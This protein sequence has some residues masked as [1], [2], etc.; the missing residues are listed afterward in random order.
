[1]KNRNSIFTTI[2]LGL[3]CFALLPGAQAVSPAPDGGYAGFNTAEGQN[4]LFSLTTGVGNTAVGWFSLWSNTD[5]SLN[6]GVGAG[7]LLFNVG[8]QTAGEGVYNTAIGTAAL[9]SN[10]TGN[11]N[12]ANGAFALFSNSTGHDNSACGSQAL[13]TNTTGFRNT[14]NGVQAL[15]SNATGVANTAN[16]YGTLYSNTEGGS[17]TANGDQALFNNAIGSANTADGVHALL[18]NTTGSGNT[19]VG[20]DAMASNTEGG[21]NTAVG[22]DALHSNST[23]IFNTAVGN[24]ALVNNTGSFNIA[25]RGGSN[26]TTGNFNIDIGSD[27]VAGESGTI[28]IGDGCCQSRAFMAGISGTGVSGSTVVVDANGQLGVTPSSARFKEQIKPMDQTSE[29]ILSLKPVSFHYTKE[30]DP[31]A[32]SQFGLVAEEV[33]EVNPDLVVRDKEGNPYSVRYDAVN[34]MLLNEFLKE[35]RKV[36]EQQTSIA[37]LKSTVAQQQK[38]MEVL[39]GKLKEQAAQIQ[40]V[41]AQ[42]EISKSRSQVVLKQ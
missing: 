31:A 9:L 40:K 36:E 35:H 32:R 3:A 38:G 7:T 15:F 5:G 14:A 8:N 33:A 16:G 30:I 10:T 4:A 28:R 20:V 18:H 41:S 22:R 21:D 11:N 2:L 29:A 23:G 6:T 17:N 1:M 42:L 34:A 26:L 13:Y 19:A 37:E 25:L 39:T 24:R 27:G 12:T